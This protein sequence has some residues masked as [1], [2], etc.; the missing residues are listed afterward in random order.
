MSQLT[1]HLDQ[2]ALQPGEELTGTLTWQTEVF[3]AQHL[4]INLFWF[5][6]GKGSEDL[7]VVNTIEQTLERPSGETRFSFRLPPSPWS[8][9]GRLI[10]IVWAVEA[11]LDEKGA[12]DRVE[13]VSAPGGLELTSWQNA[14]TP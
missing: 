8:Y 4:V 12:A 6:R 13:F 1:L 3:T 10:S 2:T 9:S 7:E 14:E 5:T 11:G